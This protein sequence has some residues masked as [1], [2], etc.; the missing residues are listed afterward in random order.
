MIYFLYGDD[1]EK[2]RAKLHSVVEDLLKKKPDAE[3]FKITADDW[4]E[5]QIEELAGGQGLFSRKFIV[6]LDGVF[7]NKEAKEVVIS[8]LDL[9]QNSENIFIFLEVKIDKP[10]LTKIEKI[11]GRV[12]EFS[13]GKKG[14]RK[15]SVGGS[16]GAGSKVGG[17]TS[18]KTL[19]LSDFNVFSLGDAFG[20]KDKKNLWVLYEKTKILEIPPEEIHG[21]LFWQV[22]VMLL[23]GSSKTAGESGLKPF[24]WSKAKT[25]LKNYS[26]E[27]IKKLSWELVK[28][29]H[30]AHGGGTALEIALEKFILAI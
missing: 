20:R 29:Y 27:E 9:L 24:V 18:G 6:S 3:F 5:S 8:K 26:W 4:N 2:A 17:G 22:K 1:K 7:E 19:S 10:T 28:I 14:G 23:A 16:G 21:L 25:F 11:K 30:E 15:F 13:A 12:Q